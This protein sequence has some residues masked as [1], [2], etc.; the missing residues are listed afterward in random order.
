MS[1]AAASADVF[2]GLA[3]LLADPARSWTLDALAGLAANL[4]ATFVRLFQKEGG[5]APLA[6]LGELRLGL[7]HR[8]LASTRASLAEIAE[9]VGYPSERALSRAFRRRYGQ[10]PGAMRK[11]EQA[12]V[13]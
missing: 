8:R 2:A 3:P 9:A 11:A 5:A 7:A 10:P 12:L 6:F 1:G 13:A 4:R